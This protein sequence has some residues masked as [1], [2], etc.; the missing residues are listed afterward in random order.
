MLNKFAV[1]FFVVVV[2]FLNK[3]L[4][5]CLQECDNDTVFEYPFIYFFKKN[6]NGRL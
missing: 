2:V 4:I 3:W 1:D 6:K 5:Q